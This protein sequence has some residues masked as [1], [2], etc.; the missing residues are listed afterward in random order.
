MPASSFEK[1]IGFCRS[2]LKR[3]RRR[4]KQGAHPV[5]TW[6]ESSR[7]KTSPRPFERDDGAT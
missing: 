1:A 7:S 2:L 4:S 6:D 3:V 5:R